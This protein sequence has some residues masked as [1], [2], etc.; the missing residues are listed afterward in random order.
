MRKSLAKLNE[1]RTKFSAIFERYGTKVG[2]NGYAERTILLKNV[3]DGTRIVTDHIWFTLTKGFWELG[4][5]KQGDIVDFHARVKEYE[6]GYV[7]HR[8]YID[9][10]EIDYK[11]SH[12]TKI[13]KHESTQ[14]SA[15]SEQS[16]RT[17]DALHA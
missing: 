12:P 17:E 3:S 7:N 4:E 16:N 6:K 15:L 13:R 1:V 9:Q 8:E 14:I 10:R 2:W 5:L 11:L